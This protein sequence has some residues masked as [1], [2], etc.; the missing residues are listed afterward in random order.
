MSLAVEGTY[1]VICKTP[2]GFITDEVLLFWPLLFEQLN[3]KAQ[4]PLRLRPETEQELA[5]K[6]WRD[7][8]EWDILVAT[9]NEYRLVRQTLD[10]LQLAGTSG[11]PT[12][13]IPSN[14][15]ARFT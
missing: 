9:T 7:R 15:R 4:F 13:D 10:L 1:P 2:V 5:T 14:F 8:P 3:L 11:I 6:L 12:E